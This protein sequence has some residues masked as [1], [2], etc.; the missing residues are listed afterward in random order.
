MG[1]DAAFTFLAN[2]T[3]NFNFSLTLASKI[4][5]SCP[6]PSPLPRHQT[7]FYENVVSVSPAS[8]NF[9]HGNHQQTMEHFLFM[10]I[11]PYQCALD[12]E[13]PSWNCLN[14]PIFKE[15]NDT[16]VKDQ[17][18]QGWCHPKFLIP[19]WQA[20]SMSRC[21]WVRFC[22]TCPEKEPGG[23]QLKAVYLDSLSLSI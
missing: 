21:M 5:I 3:W 15:G 19:T 22:L 1:E 7:P 12:L 9:W 6:Q 20:L 8:G 17:S 23:I 18:Q 11:E 13:N 14:A 10:Y 2:K 16:N 4:H